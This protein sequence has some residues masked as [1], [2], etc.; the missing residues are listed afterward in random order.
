M[1]PF[2]IFF[3][4]ALYT[5]VGGFEQF[6]YVVESDIDYFITLYQTVINMFLP[7]G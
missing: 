2:Y 7:V 6:A 4:L 5:F 1:N 3:L